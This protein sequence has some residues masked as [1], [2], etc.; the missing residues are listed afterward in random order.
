MNH[1]YRLKRSGRTQQLQPVPETARAA[2]KGSRTGKTLAQTVTAT[3]AS[4]ALGGMASLAHA[5]QAPPAITAPAANQLPQ[6]GVVTRGSANINTGSIGTNGSTALMSVNQSSQRAVIDWASFNVGSQAKVQFN[7]PSTSAVTLNNILGNNAS[8]IYGQISANG[9]VFLSNPNGVYFSPT[10]QVSV[11]G[12]VA[13]TGKANADEFMAGKASFNRAGSTGSVVNEGQLTSAAGGYIALLAPEVRNQGVVVAQAGTVALSSG[14]AITLSFNNSGTGLAGITT[15]PQTIATLVENRSAV[16]AE[17]GQIIL[18]AHALAALQ[19]SVVKNSGQLSATSLHDKGGKIVL[20]ADSIELTGTSRIEANGPQGGGTVLVGGDW[21]GSGD[22]RQAVQVTMAPGA[23]IET[24]A[25]QQGD[26]GKV[27]LWSDVHNASSVTQ[28]DGRIEAKGAGSANKGGNGGQVETSGHTLN[29]GEQVTVNTQAAGQGQAGQWLLDPANIDINST[30]TEAGSTNSSGTFTPNSGVASSIIKPDTIQTA[31]ASGDV[32]ITTTNNGTSGPGTGNITVTSDV[33]WSSV[34]KLTLTAAGGVSGAGNITINNTSGKLTIDQAGTS[35]YS[36]IIGGSGGFAKLGSGTLTLSGNNSYGGITTVS[37][38]GVLKVG[39]P[40]AIGMSI[41]TVSSGSALDLNGQVL[42]TNNGLTLNGT[43]I[44]NAGA[45]MNSGNTSATFNG[46]I[47]LGS[48]SSIV[49]EG[50]P[51]VLSTTGYLSLSTYGLTL[52]G[53]AGGSLFRISGTTGTLTKSG[54]GTWTLNQISTYTGSTSINGGTLQFEG[55]G[56]L[57]PS[58]AINIAAGATL[59]FK[60]TTTTV[61]NTITGSGAIANLNPGTTLTLSAAAALTGGTYVA[62]VNEVPTTPTFGK[63]VLGASPNL[64]G[65]VFSVTTS[66]FQPSFNSQTAIS[67]TGTATGTPTL[68]LNGTTVNSGDAM[69]GAS[70]VLNANNL[71]IGAGALWSLT[72]N[73]NTTYFATVTDATGATLVGNATASVYQGASVTESGLISGSG[74]LTVTGGGTITLSGSNT[75]SGGTT[76]SMGVVKAGRATALGTGA[77]TVNSGAALDLNGQTMTSTGMLTL[78]GTGVS[79][80]GALMNSGGAATYPGLAVLGAA[81]SIIGGS[82]SIALTNTGTTTGATY[83]LTLGG[84][85]GGSMAGVIGT[86]TGRVNKED[87]GTWVLSGSNTYSGGTFINGG[88]LQISS[89]ANLGTAPGTAATNITINGGT[90]AVAGQVSPGFAI[91]GTRLISMGSSGGTIANNG[92]YPLTVN[93][94]I[95][96]SGPVSL[97]GGD[98]TFGSIAVSTASPILVKSTGNIVQNAST[99]VSTAGG[100]ITYWADSDGSGDGAITVNAGASGSLTQINANNGDIVMGGGSGVNASA[101]VARG[102]Y[103]VLVGNYA[104]VLAGTGNVT[105]LGTSNLTTGSGVFVGSNSTVSGANVS[106]TGNGFANNTTSSNGVWLSGTASA[107]NLLTI[108]ATGGG[109]AST[110]TSGGTNYGLFLYGGVAEATGSGNV[111]INA[112]G[113]GYLAGANNHGIVLQATTGDASI[114]SVTGSVTVNATAGTSNTAGASVGMYVPLTLTGSTYNVRL[115]GSTQTGALTLRSDSWLFQQNTAYQYVKIQ[116]SGALVMEPLSGSTSF[117][118]TGLDLSYVDLSTSLSS[119]TLGKS[120]NTAPVILGPTSGAPSWP[121]ASYSVAGPISIYGDISLGTPLATTG[122]GANGVVTLSGNVT[123]VQN[124]KLTAPSLLLL[125]TGSSN[126]AMSNPYAFRSNL[127]GTVAGSGLGTVAL[128]N[129]SFGTATGAGALTVGTVGGVTGLSATGAVTLNTYRDN[130]TLANDVVTTNTGTSAITLNAGKFMAVGNTSNGNMVLSGGTITTG[131]GGRARVYTGSVAGSTG[132][133]AL[134][135]SGSGRFRYGSTETTSNFTTALGNSGIYA[136]YRERPTV[137]WTSSSSQTIYY[138]STPVSPIADAIAGL[139]NGDTIDANGILRLASNNSLAVTNANGFYNVGSYLYSRAE[140]AKGLGYLVSNP[141]LSIGQATVTV[142]A[143][144]ATKTY[145]GLGYSGGNGVTYSGFASGDTAGNAFKGSLTYWGTSQGAVNANS[146]V[147]TPGG[148]TLSGWAAINYTIQYANGTLTVA[149]APLTVRIN[150][151]ARFFNE[152]DA[153]GYKSASYSG[154]V[155]GQSATTPGVL[156]G[157]LSISRSNSGPDSNLAGVNT[158]AGTYT[159][160]LTGSGLTAA[161]YSFNYVPGNYT[162]VPADQ[163][164]V[165]VANTAATYASTPAYT[166]TSA[167]YFRSVGNTLID[168]TNNVVLTGNSFSL[169]DGAGGN[170]AFTLGA[171]SPSLSTGGQLNVGAYQLAASNIVTNANYSNTMTLTGALQV[172]PKPVTAAVTSSVSKAYDGT[173]AMNGLT[174]GVT[175]AATGDAVGASGLGAYA[176]KNAGNPV[177]YTV[178]NIVLTGT[179]ARNY[180]LTDSVS[181]T[182]SNTLAGSNGV[183]TAVPLTITANNDSKTYDGNAYSGRN[184][185]TYS[186]FVNNETAVDLSGTV[187]Y[188]GT[189]QTA[190]NAGTYTIVPSGYSSTNYAIAYVNGALTINPV[191]VTAIV[192][193]LQGSVS[194]VY[195]GNNTATLS[196]S[197]YLLTGW[198]GSDGATVTKTSGTYDTATAGTGKTV[199]VTL[200]DSD[201]AL[202]SGTL[203][204]NYNLPTSISGPVG[205]ISAKPVTVTNTARTTTYDGASTYGVLASGTAFTTTALVGSDSVASVTQ[206]PSGAGVT[207]SGIAQAGNFS[208][209]PSNAVLGVGNANNYSFSYV[210]STHT[211]SQ[212]ALTVIVG[213][214]QGTVSK[215]YDGNNTA[216]LTAGNYLLTGWATGE[217]ATVTKTTGTYDTATAGSGKTVTVAL[218]P[219]DYSA[220]GATNLANYNLPNSISGAVGNIGKAALTATG[221]SLSVTY[222]GANQSVSGFTVSGLQGSDTVDSLSSVTASGATGKNAGSYTNTVT[223]GVETNYTVTPVNGSLAI[224]KAPLTATGNSLSVTYNGANQSVSGFTVSGLQGSDTVSSLSNV[225]ASGATGKNAG[226]YT[227]TLTAGTETNYTV[228]PVNGSL[229]IA[230]AN[231][232]VT[233]NSLSVTY[234]GADQ[235]VSGFTASGLVGG[236]TASVLTGVTASRT[237]KN[238][239][240][241]ATTASGTDG[242][243]NLSFVDGSMVINKA[244]LTVRVNDDAKFVTQ[245]DAAGYR[246]VSYSGFVGGESDSV[247]GGALAISRSASGPDGNTSAA[248]SAVGSYTGALTA[249]GLTST[250][251]TLSYQ[252]GNYRIIPADQLLIKLANTSTTYGAAPSYSVTEA[253]YLNQSN[254][255]VDLTGSV[256]STVSNGTT[257]FA[258][259]DGVGGSARF[260]V[261]ANG[262]VMSGA[263]QLS[264]G[265]YQLDATGVSVSSNNFSNNLAVVGALE[266]KTAPLTPALAPTKVYDATTGLSGQNLGVAGALAGDVVSATGTGSFASKNAGTGVG[267]SVS[268]LALAG[269]DARNY[270][271]TGVGAGNTV[272][273]T[274]GTITPAPLTVNFTATDKVYDGNTSAVVTPTDN[275]F[276]G[277]VLSVSATGNFADKNVGTAKPVNVTAVAL[278][279][280]DA[281]NYTVSPTASTTASI[282]RLAAVTWVGGTTGSWFDPANWAGGAVPDLANV[283]NVTIP[284][285]VTVSFDNTPVAP[286]QAGPVSI[287]SLGSAGSLKQSAG[288]LNVGAGGVT[289]NTLTQTGGELATTGALTLGSLSQSAGSLSAGSLSTTTSYS[290]TGTGTINVTG[291]VSI[292]ATTAP[293]LLGN[294]NTGGTLNVNST[295]GSITQTAGTVLTVTGPA[296]LTASQNGTPA[297]VYLGNAGNTLSGPVTASGA[298]VTLNTTGPLTTNVTATGNA[299]LTSGGSTTLGASTVGGN[300][301]VTSTGDVTQTAPLTVAGTTTVTSTQGDVVLSNTNNNL[302]GVVTTQGNNVTVNTH[303]PQTTVVTAT[304]DASLSTPAT[305]TVSGTA[306]SLTTQSGGTTTLGTTTV[307]GDV[308]ITTNNADIAQTG[309]VLVGGTTDLNA[310]TAKV[311]LTD[312]GNGFAGVVTVV[313]TGTVTRTEGMKDDPSAL[314]RPVV[315]TPAVKQAQSAYKVTVLKLPQPSTASASETG[316]VHIE[317]RDSV[318]DAKIV[319]PEELQSWIKAAG[320]Q[321]ALSGAD[322]VELSEAGDAMRL[323]ALAERSWPLNLTLRSALGQLA[324]RLVKS[325]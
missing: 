249:S 179:D 198:V 201:Y 199:T 45:L 302:T 277:D 73:G 320:T 219:S 253:K 117:A 9:Q 217:G 297:N 143:N 94:A 239:G 144:N 147:I 177:A 146:Y 245:S 79:N 194:K 164:L 127:I 66:G 149:K 251:Y 150:N 71:S 70:L 113:G 84:A 276:A 159:G 221:N 162:I 31:L 279:G 174:L 39:S 188:G 264:A 281:A 135:G 49:A 80:G 218:A 125:G 23:S 105:L 321:L 313:G 115:G 40:T 178:S 7:Q 74:S 145:D 30:G 226:N 116:G 293:V 15:T 92:N 13:T 206:T 215:V 101:G 268:N 26:G 250:N 129:G 76:I 48:T 77:V 155:G 29:L 252:S 119:L 82:G 10:A 168:L 182:A 235:T 280:A 27:V 61:N 257:S 93:G 189:S 51:I 270:H 100:S 163:L 283:A 130:L 161:N 5:Q 207:V 254:T 85:A 110:S 103:G 104:N 304:E 120:G 298:D 261:A 157:T 36:G 248:N 114:R 278:S 303:A 20:M 216:N 222:N 296:T 299:T 238:A 173:P 128:D 214:L 90:L 37:G 193:A 142:T 186:G 32:T 236:E 190:T 22:T 317:L 65:T 285:G 112:T 262:A 204:S 232:T 263:G 139:A 42:T 181:H 319:L 202:N 301:N 272:T 246:G 210:D 134:V 41:I 98:I 233:A 289:L 180:L 106:I 187:T 3:L 136:I 132:L 126:V 46:V 311:T 6:G 294:L 35:N 111:L 107:S 244:A 83:D 56:A 230:K 17:G 314:P 4:V 306:G 54:S 91:Q 325:N 209:T 315:L 50:A 318:A 197:N 33:V 203:L 300:L 28:V 131:T 138:G 38:G 274:N 211:V 323:Q 24:N 124:G 34:N 227:N 156:G 141:T 322:G 44:G 1:V 151:D 175:G 148:L 21:Q 223:A 95:T 67:W 295:S 57:H 286:A 267:Y 121:V 96:S 290:Q 316:V 78:N 165:Q 259:S 266:V 269:A 170:T 260:A 234:N 62:S 255:I 166:V 185:V 8:Q 191:N 171:T 89:D 58:S 184:G 258:V 288:T 64:T 25:T 205:V 123:E 291:D 81:S 309:T 109:T 108:N 167:K 69:L 256:T 63:I 208:V 152:T 102:T 153:A 133:G 271:L 287:D 19:G 14:E 200:T 140:G 176:S 247:L 47:A 224:A 154:F 16:L 284:A 240:T 18:S 55:I 158:L 307:K 97:T 183:I 87:A 305:L 243:Y 2:G 137:S 231:A 196:A 242:N 160:V 228:T 273:G 192:G 60:R 237:E 75:Y 292:T 53:A 68:K 275:R 43:G 86:T 220:I 52:A 11:G 265:A 88:T 212:A 308:Q 172:N 59:A 118:S 169:N 72:N 241:Y 122:T 99:T 282:T 213:A 12:L 195:D 310:G 324:I 312:P 225:V 229:A